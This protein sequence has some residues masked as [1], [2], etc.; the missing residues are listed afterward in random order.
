MFAASNE[1][2]VRN[3]GV[4]VDELFGG[5]SSRPYPLEG[6]SAWEAAFDNCC[7]ETLPPK[8]NFKNLRRLQLGSKSLA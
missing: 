5:D 8:S 1:L 7:S 2:P 3:F 6:I 4:S